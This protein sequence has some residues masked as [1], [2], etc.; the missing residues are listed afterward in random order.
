MLGR[1]KSNALARIQRQALLAAAAVQQTGSLPDLSGTVE[2]GT[3]FA[4]LLLDERDEW[5]TPRWW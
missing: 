4:R 1:I 3:T 2:V 5:I